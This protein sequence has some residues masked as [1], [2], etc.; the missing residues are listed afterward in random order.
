MRKFFLTAKQQPWYKHTIF[1]ITADH[2]PE[3]SQF[4]SSQPYWALYGVPLAFYI[5]ATNQAARSNQIAQHAD[6][7][8]SLMALTRNQD[9]VVAFGRNLFDSTASPLAVNYLSGI[10]QMV[11]R[12]TLTIFNGQQVTELYDLS[13]D[14]RLKKNLAEEGLSAAAQEKT[15]KAILQQYNNRLISNNLCP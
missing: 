4:G 9:T 5:P 12:D 15:L 13:A 3:K 10:Y 7:L 1:V 2:T 14:P 11:W 6:I 8:P